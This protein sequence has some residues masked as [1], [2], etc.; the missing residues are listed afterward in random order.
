MS[1]ICQSYPISQIQ[2]SSSPPAAESCTTHSKMSGTHRKPN[3]AI[4]KSFSFLVFSHWFR[5]VLAFGGHSVDPLHVTSH[6]IQTLLDFHIF[7]NE[8]L[9]KSLIRAYKVEVSMHTSV[10]V[11]HSLTVI[12][13][14]NAAWRRRPNGVDVRCCNQVPKYVATREIE[15]KEV[16][17][18]RCKEIGHT[19]PKRFRVYPLP[20]KIGAR[21]FVGERNS[22]HRIMIDYI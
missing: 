13:M 17:L 9:R 6:F 18:F 11:A 14:V 15:G 4:V 19:G 5:S 3:A 8:S 20:H 1:W 10:V 7:S 22:S 21:E 16:I 12:R 2:C